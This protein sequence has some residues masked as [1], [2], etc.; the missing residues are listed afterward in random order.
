M[1]ALIEEFGLETFT[2]YADG[3]NLQLADGSAA[4]L[5]RCHPHR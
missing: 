4:A 1:Y 2:Q 3:D 5:P